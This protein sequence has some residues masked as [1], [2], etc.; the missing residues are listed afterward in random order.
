MKKIL[1]FLIVLTVLFGITHSISAKAEN[2]ETASALYPEDSKY[3]PEYVGNTWYFRGYKKNAPDTLLNVKAQVLYTQKRDNEDY[4][5]IHA[6]KMGIRYLNKKRD[7]GVYMRVIK[8]PFPLFGFPID[9]DLI[10]AMPIIK[11]PFKQGDKWTHVGKARAVILFIP[12]EKNIRSDFEVVGKKVIKTPAGEIETW[13]IKVIV[14][15]GDGK[16]TEENYWYGKGFGYSMADTS[17]HYAELVG[18]RFYDEETGKW[19]EKIP[20]EPQTYE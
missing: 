16:P 13:H 9:V 6:P 18:Y 4:Y 8:Y 1:G 19:N 3:Y 15:E 14:D 10:P 17:G 20:E 11:F 12:I 5:Y 7:D 2:G